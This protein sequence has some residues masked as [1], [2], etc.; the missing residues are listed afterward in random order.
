MDI[1]P[2]ITDSLA[3]LKTVEFLGLLSG[4]LCVWFLIKDNL[5]TWP[6]GIAY[7]L[8]SFVVFYQAKL[9][10]DFI[11][12]FFFLG[13]NIYGW[14]Y[15]MVGKPKTQIELPITTATRKVLA[16]SIG[17]GWLGAL[18]LGYLL[19]HFTDAALPYWDSAVTSFSLVAMWLTAR[20]KLENWLFWL[21]I[22]ILATGI[23]VY[24]ELYFYA[25]LYAVYIIMAG[26]GW[27]NWIKLRQNQIADNLVES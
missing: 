14:Y 19:G 7:V 13:M 22:D 5:L 8:C 10:A 21:G 12:H 3:H 11:L 9:Y 20:K 27:L 18:G 17:I 23:Y 16:T 15:W 24:K 1:W 26:A 4:L 2:S 25:L 6:F